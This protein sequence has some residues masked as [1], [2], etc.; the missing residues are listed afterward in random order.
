MKNKGRGIVLFVFV[1]AISIFLFTQR[2]KT[3]SENIIIT[4]ICPSGCAASNHQ[5]IEI[6]NKSTESINLSGWKFWEDS[7][8]HSITLSPSSTVTS[9][10]LLPGAYAIITQNDVVFFEDHPEVTST[11]FDSTWT[12]LTKTGEEIGIKK[13]TG[14]TDFIEKFVYTSINNYSLERISAD[15]DPASSLQWKEHPISSTPG[16]ENYWWADGEEDFNHIPTAHI[17]APTSTL[18]NT[19]TFFDGS[20]SIDFENLIAQYIWTIENIQFEGVS[21]EYVFSTTSPERIFLTVYDTDGASSTVSHD[22]EIV[23]DVYVEETDLQ[24]FSTSTARIVIN[25]FLSDPNT[26]EK[27]WIEL[28]NAGDADVFLD[29]YSLYD[30]VGKIAIVTG[31]IPESGF[32]TI[33]LASSKLNQSGDQISLKDSIGN[34]L[35][36]VS[37]G[38]WSDSDET[39]NALAPG[40][41]HSSARVSDGEDTDGDHDDF[42]Y[43]ITPTPGLPNSITP[44]EIPPTSSETSVPTI[45]NPGAPKA[46]FVEGSVVINEFVSDPLEG[47]TEFVELY[48]TTGNIISLDDWI[49]QDGS[50]AKTVL[51]GSISSHNFFVIEKPKGSLNNSGDLI[52]LLDPSGKE[53]DR[54][55]YGLWNGEDATAAAPVK[56]QSGVR[57]PDGHDTGIYE[58]DF[59]LTDTITKGKTNIITQTQKPSSSKT[60]TTSTPLVTKT[61]STSSTLVTSTP[62]Y[63]SIDIDLESLPRIVEALPNPTGSDTEKEYIE[64]YNPH[65][66]EI[67][68]AGIFLDDGEK[69][70]KPFEFVADATL[71]PHEYRAW[72]SKETKISLNNTTDKIRILD[73]EENVLEEVEYSSAKEDKA[74]TFANTLWFW[75][76]TLTPH[77][78]NPHAPVGNAVA[79]SKSKAKTTISKPEIKTTLTQVRNF[80]IGTIA[81]FTGVVLVPP[82]VLSSQYMYVGDSSGVGIQVYSYKKDFPEV[83]KGDVV[84]LAGELGETSG[85]MRVKLASARD[86]HVLTTSTKALIPHLVDVADVGEVYEGGLIEVAGEV[87][88]IKGS[89]VYLDDG[90]DEIKVYIRGGSGIDKKSFKEGSR[91]SIA[92]IVQETKSGYHLSPRDTSD[93]RIEGAV[94][95]EKIYSIPEDKNISKMEIFRALV[96]G[97]F[98]IALVLGVKLYGTRIKEFFKKKQ[99]DS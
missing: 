3:V 56:G 22:I 51:T 82:G 1:I 93:V 19:S 58:T 65:D 37:Y 54:A 87:T 89:Y 16:F 52:T 20:G 90:T 84:E 34:I 32:R 9:T 14:S 86:V 18:I 10:I 69:G 74:Y 23:S 27:E 50:L 80:D 91:V 13:G 45:A 59:S 49:L 5:W 48:N 42:S 44:K 61:K 41:G 53:I 7:V 28:Y 66:R 76:E 47:E 39:D 72:Y 96:L 95:G 64:L 4:E 94:A 77:L 8:N 79:S 43:T 30:G 12:T 57:S 55:V 70:S 99:N 88:G 15:G 26:G 31:T 2:A 78:E 67:S 11:V 38:E 98:G 6:Y 81:K 68:L 21:V 92:G 71:Y 46:T 35:D 73:S 24:E 60:T 97:L 75:S 33:Y 17:T 85:E 83:T 63:E 62:A 40:K 36:A 25:E 29:E